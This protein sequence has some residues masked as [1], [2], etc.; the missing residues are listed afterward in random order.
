MGCLLNKYNVLKNIFFVLFAMQKKNSFFG[1]LIS[2]L[3]IFI[4][5]LSIEMILTKILNNETYLS[6]DRF[7]SYLIFFLFTSSI[8]ESILIIKKYSI[9]IKNSFIS[10][11]DLIIVECLI[12]FITS[13]IVLVLFTI[14]FKI[15]A[16]F[17][18]LLLIMFSISI[19]AIYISNYLI[20]IAAL[21][22]DLDRVI[23][24][25]FQ[26]LFW[27]SP[28]IYSV[29]RLNDF[30]RFLSSISPLSIFLSLKDYVFYSE[31]HSNVLFS[32]ISLFTIFVIIY[33]LGNKLRL[34]IKGIL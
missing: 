18:Y 10:I 12:Q 2:I 14:F 27:L 1:L 17:F 15:E 33:V 26:L 20:A 16:Y 3:P 6:G 21:V 5:A 29:A 22:D 23:S 9:F 28:I 11:L 13:F 8:S 31:S 32:S 4:T 7:F 24:L 30:F 19:V 25:I 34:N